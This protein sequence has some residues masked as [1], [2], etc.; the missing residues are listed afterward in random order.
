LHRN[1]KDK[2]ERYLA[3]MLENNSVCAAFALDPFNRGEAIE[4]I[5]EAMEK[6][7]VTKEWKT[8]I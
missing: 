2:L 7:L 8:G 4:N 3:I 5:L 6:A 1:A